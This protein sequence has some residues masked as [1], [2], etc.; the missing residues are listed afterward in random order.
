MKEEFLHYLWKYGLFD[1]EKLIDNEGNRINVINPGEYNRDSGPDFFNTR[2]RIAGMEWA[3]NVE[4]HVRASDFDNHRHNTDPAYNNVILHLVAENDRKVFNSKGDEVMTSVLAY[5]PQ[6]YDKYLHLVN[7]PF[8]IACQ[9][10]INEL[11]L[12]Y[13]RHWLGSLVI[14]RI[15]EKS[16]QIMKI[17]TMTGNDWE[18]T[19]YRLLS[20]YFGFRVNTEPF[21]LLASALPF[22]IIRKHAD[23]LFQIE[24]L[25]FGTAGMLEEG[26]FREAVNDKYYLALIKEYKILSAKYSLHPVH[27]WIW[28]FARLRPANFPTLR[29]SQL[30]A[31]LSVTGGL[32]SRTLE[33]TDIASL[34]N[35]FE[36]TA[37]EYW[38]DHF[39]FGRKSRSYPKC[40]G[41][42]ATDILL[43]NAVIPVI[44]VYGKCRDSAGICERAISFLEDIG[45]EEN[46]IIEEWKT[47]GIE[48]DSA[49]ISQALIQLRNCYCR[50]RRCLDCRIGAKLIGMGKTLKKSDELI[51]E[52]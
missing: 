1:H 49:F 24:A 11:D 37:S 45:P 48:A 3:G 18:E 14:E 5:D 17:C 15:Q 41:S 35:L 30:A 26:L 40:T 23:D 28:K 31:M 19:F 36:V 33:A 4:I 29:I 25:L 46:S 8:I 50:K 51:L 12:L 22:K 39:V 32:F 44:F 34:R 42:Q 47:A 27:G 9:T 6:V 52:P 13:I 16:E 7:N 20:R 43:I 21:E 2:L 38:N 10:G